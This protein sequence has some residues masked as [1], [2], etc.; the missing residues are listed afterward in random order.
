VPLS[1]S[2]GSQQRKNTFGKSREPNAIHRRE[3]PSASSRDRLDRDAA[4]SRERV[5]GGGEG[6]G[7][8]ASS[9]EIGS[10][11]RFI[12]HDRDSPTLASS[13]GHSERIDPHVRE[14][15]RTD[16]ESR[17]VAKSSDGA[18][19]AGSHS[20][21]ESGNNFN[22]VQI[23]LSGNNLNVQGGSPSVSHSTSRSKLP[24]HR[25]SGSS[26]N[27]N[28][29]D[30]SACDNGAAHGLGGSG[31]KDAISGSP[32]SSRVGE[33]LGRGMGLRFYI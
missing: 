11:T 32:S 16:R 6:G 22:T 9:P 2:E 19:S 33:G 17:D 5:R 24:S 25:I 23:Q 3:S 21:R 10:R 4:P 13:R 8:D 18:S 31:G 1:D 29:T 12:S 15:E 7:G 26:N 27:S 20:S 28:A 30:S 14:K